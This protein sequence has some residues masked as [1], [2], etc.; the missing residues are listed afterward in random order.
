MEKHQTLPQTHSTKERSCGK[1][2]CGDRHWLIWLPDQDAIVVR[3]LVLRDALHNSGD[4][5]SATATTALTVHIQSGT[6]AMDI[7][8]FTVYNAMSTP[9][10]ALSHK[11]CILVP[12]SNH[13]ALWE[14]QVIALVARTCN[15]RIGAIQ[16]AVPE[17]L[18]N[19]ELP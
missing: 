4:I 16:G 7:G 10:I 6:G 17:S 1:C 15:T 8:G 13:P 14:G 9:W 2:R 19:H 3:A 18:V 11:L 5:D 12:L